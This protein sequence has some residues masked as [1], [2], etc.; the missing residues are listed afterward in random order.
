MHAHFCGV[1]GYLQ[2]SLRKS[3]SPKLRGNLD[4]YQLR[5][6]GSVSSNNLQ[7]ESEGTFPYFWGAR[8]SKEKKE[9]HNTLKNNSS[10]EKWTFLVC[11][12]HFLQWNLLLWSFWCFSVSQLMPRMHFRS[13]IEGTVILLCKCVKL[14]FDLYRFKN[15]YNLFLYWENLHQLLSSLLLHYVLFTVLQLPSFK[16]CCILLRLL[17]SVTVPSLSEKLCSSSVVVLCSINLS[18]FF[19]LSWSAIFFLC[20]RVGEGS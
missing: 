15:K 8:F 11:S 1:L 12:W 5:W 20:L 2:H 13:L 10:I 18:Y 14:Y 7:G 6:S 16:C 4:C 9:S 3:I 19:H 17:V